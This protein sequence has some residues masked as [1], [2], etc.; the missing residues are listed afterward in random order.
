MAEEGERDGETER[1]RE[2]GK[3]GRREGGKEGIGS[4]RSKTDIPL[5]LSPSLSPST[6]PSLLSWRRDLH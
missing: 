6:L 1:R 2:G 4:C 3:E 5:S